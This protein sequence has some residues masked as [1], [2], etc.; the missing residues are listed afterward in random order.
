MPNVSPKTAGTIH[1][2]RW[3]EICPWLILIKALRVSLMLRV[4]V[5][6]MLGVLF[7]QWGGATLDRSSS[8]NMASQLVPEPGHYDQHKDQHNKKELAL[9]VVD[10]TKE[11]IKTNP[12][13]RGW[14]CLTEPFWSFVVD[15]N[16]SG[17]SSFAA[18]LYGLW[19]IVVWGVFGGAIA[20]VAAVYLTR[21]ETISPLQA[22]R[23]ATTVWPSVMGA[24]L[25]VLCVAGVLGLPLVL[26]GSLFHFNILQVLVGLL[27]CLVLVLGLILAVVLIGLLIGWPLMWACLSV[28]RSDAFDGVSRCYAYVYQR[29][30][31][32]AF[33]VLVAASLAFLGEVVVN[34][35]AT[36]TIALSE[37][38]ISLGSGEAYLNELL[39]ADPALL[40]NQAINA[41]KWGLASLVAAYPL[42]CLWPMAVGIY[43]LL[44][45]QVD[46][47]EMDEI[48]LDEISLPAASP[49]PL[50]THDPTAPE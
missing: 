13:A 7:T 40:A 49:K 41:W 37:R 16:L 42:A 38:A 3:N 5:L 30:L 21:G 48:S 25:I 34:L 46:A 18:L 17:R 45:R 10:F 8:P 27:W 36:A 35:F 50:P 6:A 29:P 14:F 33:Y 19:A 4:L 15:R 22:L 12:L 1:E 44:R 26:L 9:T 20:R 43:L 11:R 31:H 2:I 23:D 32:L 39:N 24:P 28:E 47:T